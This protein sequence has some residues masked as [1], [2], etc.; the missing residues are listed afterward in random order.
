MSEEELQGHGLLTGKKGLVVGVANKR[1]IAWGIARR[2][3]AEGAELA[4]TYVGDS[5]ERRVRPLAESIDS[6]IIEP[7]DVTQPEQIEA[8]FSR[9]KSLSSCSSGGSGEQSWPT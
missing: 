1:S 9:L 6:P 4:F 8:L 2:A 5:L 7:L 3:H